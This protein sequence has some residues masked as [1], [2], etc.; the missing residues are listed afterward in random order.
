MVLD[1]APD[2]FEETV[3]WIGKGIVYDTGGLTS[4][5]DRHAWDENGH[6]GARPFWQPLEQL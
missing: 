3:G 4:V 1:Y 5:E 2:G 6:G